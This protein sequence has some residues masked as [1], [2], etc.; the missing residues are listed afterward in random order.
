ME[1]SNIKGLVVGIC[2]AILVGVFASLAVDTFFG[3]DTRTES[4]LRGD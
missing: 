4:P 3:D 2:L 1:D